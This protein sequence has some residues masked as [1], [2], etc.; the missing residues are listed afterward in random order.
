[1]KAKKLLLYFHTIRYLRKKQLYYQAVYRIKKQIT[2]QRLNVC[3]K[4]IKSVDHITLQPSIPTASSYN[5]GVFEFLNRR[6]A[7]FTAIDWDFSDYGKL[8]AYNLNYF[9]FLN[10]PDMDVDLGLN[11][12]TDFCSSL[13]THKEASESYTI[14]LRGINWIKFFTNHRIKKPEFDQAL[15]AQY[16][17][18]ASN[19]EYHLLGNHLLENGFSMLFG[20]YYFQNDSFYNIATGILHSELE[21]QILSDGAHFEL[22]PMYHQILLFRL[23]DAINLVQSNKWKNGELLPFLII[24]ASAMLGWLKSVTF[25]NGDIPMV[26]DAAFG[27]APTSQQLFAYASQFSIAPGDCRLAHSGYRM[28]ASPE[29]ELFI[30]VG[31]I[32]PDYIPGHA[33]SDTFNFVLYVNGKPIIVDTGT[34]TYDRSLRR[35]IERSTF[36]HNTV[37]VNDQEQSEIWGVFRVARR[38]K[39]VELTEAANEI[40]CVHD[41]FN[42]IG[43]K[44][45]RTWR[46]SEQGIEILDVLLGADSGTR[47]TAYIHFHPNVSVTIDGS[48]IRSQ[49]LTI[50]TEKQDRITL[51]EYEQAAGFN[52]TSKGKVLTVY[53]QDR[54]KTLITFN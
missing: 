28:I 31:S 35:Q 1:M 50:R 20:A 38:A 51:D 5:D 21:E 19:L 4:K 37:M 47:G 14:S 18:L 2:P 30:D 53:F 6:K 29:F 3:H 34:S 16:R 7:F 27:I 44:H 12:I 42:R 10:Q 22:S 8:W 24:K 32:G 17:H 52:S 26:N 46:W 9:D 48:T 43:I 33:H 36:S 11:L 40:T 49:G 41:G 15:L 39:I 45:Q 23:L 13:E 54:L 25:K